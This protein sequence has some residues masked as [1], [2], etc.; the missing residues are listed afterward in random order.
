M[1]AEFDDLYV[2]A[3]RSTL[4]SEFTS[5]KEGIRQGYGLNVS[6]RSCTI[7]GIEG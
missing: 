3:L 1:N 7:S 6:L 5:W 4:G 2:T